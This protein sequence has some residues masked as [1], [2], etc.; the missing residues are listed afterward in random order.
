GLGG[1]SCG[2]GLAAALALS[3]PVYAGE[4]SLQYPSGKLPP[5]LL[6]TVNDS[7]IQR[8]LS[9]GPQE[10]GINVWQGPPVLRALL[11]PDR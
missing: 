11:L 10:G 7:A 8:F 6:G 5:W 9:R 2:L 1:L 4:G 3:F